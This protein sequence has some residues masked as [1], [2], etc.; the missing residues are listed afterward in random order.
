MVH[1]SGAPMTEDSTT[2]PCAYHQSH[3]YTIAIIKSAKMCGIDDGSF[4]S[5]AH[6][7]KSAYDGIDRI[8]R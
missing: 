5:L 6:A 7:C 4:C 3:T 2:T 1:S 8:L